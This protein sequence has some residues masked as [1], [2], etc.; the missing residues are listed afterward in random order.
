[1]N[2]RMKL[3]LEK[4]RGWFFLHFVL[5]MLLH[6]YCLFFLHFVVVVEVD[7]VDKLLLDLV[8][9]PL[10]CVSA[11]L[12]PKRQAEKVFSEDIRSSC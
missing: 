12:I 6:C 10:V 3:V 2:E 7:I 4:R 9:L 8:A 1:M 5:L 11:C